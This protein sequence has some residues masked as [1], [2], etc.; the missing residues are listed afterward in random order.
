VRSDLAST[1]EQSAG[2]ISAQIATILAL[3]TAGFRRYAT[4]R[5][6]TV[7]SIFTN[8]TF[9]FL[10][11]YVLLAAAA[12][13]PRIGV[14]GGY[15]SAQLATYCWASLGLIGMVMLW[16]WTELSDRIRTGDVLADLLRPVH[17]VISYLAVDLGRA[18]HASL[19]RLVVPMLVGATFFTLYVPRRPGTY[20]LLLASVVLAVVV[21]FGCRFLVN[22]AGYWLLETRGINLIWTFATAVLA[23]LSFPLHFLPSWLVTALWVATPFPSILQAPLDVLVEYGSTGYSV[24]VTAGQAGWVVVLLATCWYVQHRADRK[25]VIQGG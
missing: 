8:S 23:G 11:C 13:A 3:A 15:N 4:Y 2:R 6:A 25:L 1:T 18:A 12:A 19:T 16:G 21:S 24:A 5:P 22:A 20:P 14:A 17:P 9:G 7:A 10:R